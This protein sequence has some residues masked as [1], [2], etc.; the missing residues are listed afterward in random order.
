MNGSGRARF[1]T[2][3]G[4]LLMTVLLGSGC[5]AAQSVTY[6]DPNGPHT[7]YG[8]A[9]EP[10]AEYGSD[11]MQ[12]ALDVARLSARLNAAVA[13]PEQ[14]SE[15]VSG[16]TTDAISALAGSLARSDA[17][18]AASFEQ[19]W[20]DVMSTPTRA[21][22]RESIATNRIPQLWKAV[23]PSDPRNDPS[24]TAAVAASVLDDAAAAFDQ[25]LA[26][27]TSS[28]TS[29][30]RTYAVELVRVAQQLLSTHPPEPLP[31]TRLS[32]SQHAR[33]DSL[34]ASLTTDMLQVGNGS[35]PPDVAERVSVRISDLSEAV[36]TATGIDTT[37][38]T[39]TRK[40]LTRLR[41][42]ADVAEGIGTSTA[43]SQQESTRHYA[44]LVRAADRATPGIATIDPSAVGRIDHLVRVDIRRTLTLPPADRASA[45]AQLTSELSSLT[46]QM[47]QELDALADE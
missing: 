34:F 19:A 15:Q 46:G 4:V 35:V 16:A 12:R 22:A 27:T 11:A 25:A 3:A 6:H 10:V 1:R 5:G 31:P 36:S 29:A 2:A 42:L 33:I 24:W 37:P 26:D 47:Q 30:Q 20:Q 32:P 28:D 8:S 18:A 41:Q 44:A 43:L 13:A 40:D 14:T 9:S 17:A 38:A 21:S 23:T 45:V 39:T 7:A